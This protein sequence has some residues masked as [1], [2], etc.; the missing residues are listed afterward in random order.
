MIEL[1]GAELKMNNVNTNSA[2]QSDSID[3]EKLA[4]NNNDFT[5]PVAL[6]S[7]S[8]FSFSHSDNASGTIF[9]P[10][11]A[12]FSSIVRMNRRPSLINRQSSS[13]SSVASSPALSPSTRG[14]RI[15]ANHLS[16]IVPSPVAGSI[17]DSP[18]VQSINIATPT[19]RILPKTPSITM[20]NA[21][22]PLSKDS[23]AA[24]SQNNS[25]LS[26]PANQ[27]HILTS[28]SNGI[29]NMDNSPFQSNNLSSAQKAISRSG[30]AIRAP[31]H[32]DSI[33]ISST[34]PAKR[35]RSSS[36]SQSTPPETPSAIKSENNEDSKM[37]MESSN[38]AGEAIERED[39]SDE[40]MY[41]E[42]IW[43]LWQ[44]RA[45]YLIGE[46]RRKLKKQASKSTPHTPKNKS[47]KHLLNPEM[48]P[49]AQPLSAYTPYSSAP[50]SPIINHQTLS[51]NL[52]HR[53]ALSDWPGP[54]HNNFIP[55]SNINNNATASSP[56]A[57]H[58]PI[59][60]ST[61][62]ANSRKTVNHS[63]NSIAPMADD[64]ISIQASPSFTHFNPLAS[65]SASTTTFNSIAPSPMSM[66]TQLPLSSLQHPPNVFLSSS[67]PFY[68]PPHPSQLTMKMLD[69]IQILLT[70]PVPPSP[71][72]LPAFELLSAMLLLPLPPQK[73][74]LPP[75]IKP[76]FNYD[77]LE[78]SRKNWSRPA[79][80]IQ[81][82]SD[83][84]AE[85]RNQLKNNNF[86][87]PDANYTAAEIHH[88]KY[89]PHLKRDGGGSSNKAKKPKA[90]SP[91]KSA[92]V[93]PSRPLSS[94]PVLQPTRTSSRNQQR[95]ARLLGEEA[96][97]PELLFDIDYD[98][99]NVEEM[100]L[101]EEQFSEAVRVEAV[102][103]KEGQLTV[104]TGKF[105]LKLKLN[106]DSAA[107]FMDTE[108]S[109]I[110]NANS[111][112][113]KDEKKVSPIKRKRKSKDL[114][115][116][117]HQGELHRLE[118]RQQDLQKQLTILYLKKESL[119]KNPAVKQRKKAIKNNALT[120][121]TA[122]L[123]ASPVSSP[124]LSAISSGTVTPAKISPF[125]HATPATIVCNSPSPSPS[126]IHAR[127]VQAT[128]VLSPNSHVS[129]MPPLELSK[130]QISI[131]SIAAAPAPSPSLNHSSPK[132]MLAS[133]VSHYKALNPN[134]SSNSSHPVA[135]TTE[136]SVTVVLAQFQQDSNQTN[137][138]IGNN[139]ELTAA[140]S[141]E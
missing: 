120:I 67:A 50:Q 15:S 49:L 65:P 87:M 30:R 108:S 107:Q 48:S 140:R 31:V 73:D 115:S 138:K 53:N 111:T 106:S 101:E 28:S 79:Y 51:G 92:P 94:A 125:H 90:H 77:W 100:E 81:I 47:N 136:G 46:N 139:A 20:L 119:A 135:T 130:R 82:L 109:A 3:V 40:T 34:A 131:G 76:R 22:T 5:M 114:D 75:F 8:E 97:S 63:N 25:I 84:D 99:M 128:P 104:S 11:S 29:N 23:S 36:T 37:E 74:N 80:L 89:S 83:K 9:S 72:D 17:A 52:S 117:Q 42:H 4:S 10:S 19:F 126:T 41:Y 110:N 32:H 56:R 70:T 91:H 2:D 127:A 105:K 98:E 141:N 132:P 13:G 58:S 7:Q 18:R 93:R 133:F 62:I 112:N 129:M 21:S 39:L 16:V 12:H 43:T 113:L 24:H 60:P 55:S 85:H 116:E 95:R 59:A 33:M 54:A 45:D 6:R 88:A 102:E 44:L 26:S 61:P 78:S 66:S 1:D 27:P 35:Q 38:K 103:S 68:I 134:A 64:S 123:A 57:H 71:E 86:R 124:V 122:N 14:L 69:D 121:V 118:Q 137:L 96:G